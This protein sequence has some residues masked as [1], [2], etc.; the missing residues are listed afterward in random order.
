LFF[1]KNIRLVMVVNRKTLTFMLCVVASVATAQPASWVPGG[2]HPA[3][4][5]ARGM[6]GGGRVVRVEDITLWRSNV[7]WQD[8]SVTNTEHHAENSGFYRIDVQIAD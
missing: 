6:M 4:P 1:Q 2:Q 8:T 3:G 5:D 7:P